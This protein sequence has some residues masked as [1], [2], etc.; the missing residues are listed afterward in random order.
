M[1]NPLKVSIMTAG[2]TPGDAIS[3]YAIST[4]RILR[5]WGAR[6]TIYADNIAPQYGAIA[7]KSQFYQDN[8]DGILWFHYTLY[9]E[10][11]EI[12][13]ASREFKI[14]DY[15][16]IC[17]PHLFRGQNAHL[18][19]LT[20]KGIELR[21]SLRD[22]FDQYIIHTEYMRQELQSMGYP[23][24]KI[25]KI[26]YCIDTSH[27]TDGVADAQ[28]ATDLAKLDYFLLVGRIVPQKDVLALVEVFA[29]INKQRPD[30]VLVIVGNRDQTPKY[31][32]QI[33]QLVAARGVEKRVMFTGQVNNPAVLAALFANARL[34]FVTSEWESFCVPIA[35]S[36][37][38]G[39]PTAV[40]L[41]PPMPE[42]AGPAGI[43]FDMANPAAA[44]AEVLALLDDPQRYQTMKETAVS[45]AQ[46]YTSASLE[47]NLQSFLR[48]IQNEVTNGH[49][50]TGD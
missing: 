4:A 22:K 2:L 31:Q 20:Q 8:G 35:E 28:L 46:Q 17:P 38:F 47:Q 39:V 12:A 45:W 33:D 6:V 30:T 7:Q 26:F 50:P 3:N 36:L 18:E 42:V 9:S 37:F 15:H 43:V 21:P 32:R 40:H 11:V 5:Q 27:F 14:M 24:E 29:E 25:N 34:L 48:K 19:Y 44:A 41:A 10:N 23:P 1:T 13:L 49:L 16:G